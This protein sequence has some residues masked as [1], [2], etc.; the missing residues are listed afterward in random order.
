MK[1]MIICFCLMITILTIIEKY[2]HSIFNRQ[3]FTYILQDE[4][5]N[6]YML[7]GSKQWE[8]TIKDKV[9]IKENKIIMNEKRRLNND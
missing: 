1:K 6:R 3:W 5:N 8:F 9:I 2:E 4:Q 7:Q